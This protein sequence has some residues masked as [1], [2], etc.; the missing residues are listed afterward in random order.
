MAPAELQAI[1]AIAGPAA[2]LA[3]LGAVFAGPRP[4]MPDIF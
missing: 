3:L 1:G 4:W 2:D